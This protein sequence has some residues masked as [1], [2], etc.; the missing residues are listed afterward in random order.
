MEALGG[1]VPSHSVESFD[2]AIY[3]A[4]DAANDTGALLLSPACASYDQFSDYAA[5]GD[6]FR[7]IARGLGAR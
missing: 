4:Y 5:R 2:E 7:E 1:Y 6:R 3:A